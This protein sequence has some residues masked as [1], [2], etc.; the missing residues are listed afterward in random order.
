[1]YKQLFFLEGFMYKHFNPI[2]Y[3]NSY[4][5]DS[6]R[7]FESDLCT[8]SQVSSELESGENSVLSRME[9]LRAFARQQRHKKLKAEG[10]QTSFCF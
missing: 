7:Y 4:F 10:M 8:Q 1:M 6:E 9:N 5:V 3:A 2:N